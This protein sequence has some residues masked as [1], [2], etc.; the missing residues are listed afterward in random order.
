MF[1]SIP[2]FQLQNETPLPRHRQQ[3]SWRVDEENEVMFTFKSSILPFCYQWM[4]IE[5][6][7]V[8]FLMASFEMFKIIDR[9]G[10]QSLQNRDF[11]S[12]L[13]KLN[14]YINVLLGLKYDCFPNSKRKILFT[15]LSPSAPSVIYERRGEP[16]H[17]FMQSFTHPFF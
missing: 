12:H 10:R 4:Y 5:S 13:Q 9:N 7:K 3:E 6:V 15:H 16:C 2:I 1:I 14:V 11:Q 8:N 17:V